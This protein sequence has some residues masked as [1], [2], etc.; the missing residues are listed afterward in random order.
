MVQYTYDKPSQSPME[1]PHWKSLEHKEAD[2][3]L[4]NLA[5]LKAAFSS[6][7]TSS[8]GIIDHSRLALWSCVFGYCEAL[9]THKQ[10]NSRYNIYPIPLDALARL[11]SN[12]FKPEAADTHR[13]TAQAVSNWI[14]GKVASKSNAKD[15]LHANSLYVVLRGNIDGKSID[16]FG[17]ALC[18]VIG[19]RQLG[20]HK[21]MLTLSEDHAYESHE[22]DDTSGSNSNRRMCTCEVAVPG[23]TKIMKAKRGQETAN[24]F[25]ANIKSKLTPETSWL[26]MGT[27][28]VYCQTAPMI[29]A[30]ALGNLN[31]LIDHKGIRSEVN[32]VPLMK[33]KQ[34]LLWILK[35][36]GHL[37]MFPF[38]LCELGYTEEHL[39]SP[40]GD[41]RI[42]VLELTPDPVTGIEALYHQAIECSKA[43]YNDKQVYP[44]CYMGFFHKDGG[45]DEEYRLAVAV[46]YFG[47]AAQVARQYS[48][49]WGDSLQLV[50][51][52]TK[53]SEYICLEI[54]SEEH[55]AWK[56]ENNAVDCGK[57]LITF[58]DHLLCWEERCNERF[59][60][61]LQP[62]HKT[63][64]TKAWQL[65]SHSARTKVFDRAATTSRRL[66][67]SL[68]TALQAPKLSI[69]D[70][71]LSIVF[72]GKRQRKRK[73]P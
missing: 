27:A 54:L 34:E 45:K 60:P 68:G 13:E 47:K 10:P 12:E 73:A 38:A 55:G 1:S 21:S 29:L 70:L 59:L 40:R 26:Y 22:E 33:M 4:L 72:E 24:T 15:E 41:E 30:A 18:T 35:D 46:K 66:S 37:D 52:M 57:Q 48:Y 2:R 64:I 5:D 23:N 36:A 20:F 58:F 53:L 14:W 32:S 43:H 16:C 49:E 6:D 3:L 69:T 9:T 71:H 19:L 25:E 67:G 7:V 11:V 28:P 51:T 39:T 50:R 8:S 42:E 17:A 44:Y 62:D 56:E 63:G 65:L 31:S 61:I